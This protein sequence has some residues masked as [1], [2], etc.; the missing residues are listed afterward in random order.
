M[1]DDRIHRAVSADG[2]EIAGRVRGQGPPLVLVHPPV[3]DPDIAWEALVPYLTGRFT[4]YRPGLRGR[5]LSGD[6]PDHSPAR[7]Q[8]DFNAFVDSIGGPVYLMS[9]SDGG[10]LALGAA[11]HCGSVTAV[12]AYE[13]SV[14]ALMREDE[15]ARQ[16]AMVKKVGAATADGRLTDAAHIFHHYVCTDNEFNALDADYLERQGG[17]WPPL[18]RELQQEMAYEGPEPTDPDVLGRID[19]P[20]L[21][22]L[23]QQTRLK[24]WFTDSAQHIAQNVADSQVREL[25]GVG[26]FAPLVAPEPIAKELISFFESVR[27]L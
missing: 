16:G 22:L 14:W 19:A 13:P 23:A 17:N 25:P 15:L 7:L 11:A 1:T 18:L 12:A 5:G 20:V 10:S 8:E 24:T 2:T 9:W 4:C 27:S 21:V 26:H 6:N 3:V